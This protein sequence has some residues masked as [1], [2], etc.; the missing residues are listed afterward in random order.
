LEKY[1]NFNF[2]FFLI[3]SEAFFQT[4]SLP[5]ER[6]WG[7]NKIYPTKYSETKKGDKKPKIVYFLPGKNK[8]GTV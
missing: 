4:I 5:A 1:F 2:D 3:V 7:K 8:L 6:T